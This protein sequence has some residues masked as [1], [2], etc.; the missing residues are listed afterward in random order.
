MVMPGDNV[1]VT[2][3]LSPL[4][5]WKKACVSR[6]AKAVVRWRGVVGRFLS[7]TTASGGGETSSLCRKVENCKNSVQQ[8]HGLAV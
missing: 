6:F 5:R 3:S 2:V 7:I 8:D 4:S 1:S